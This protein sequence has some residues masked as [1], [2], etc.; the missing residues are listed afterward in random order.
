M[1]PRRIFTSLALGWLAYSQTAK[2]TFEVASVRPSA[3]FTRGVPE[4]EITDVTGDPE[5]ITYLR[6][7]MQELLLDAY[8]VGPD[9]I[10]GPDW[11][12]TSDVRA[13]ARFDISAKVPPGTTK[14]QAV[15]MLR[16]VLAERFRLALH[17]ETK[18]V[19]GFAL[20]LAK[21]GSK[22]K[23]SQGA[24]AA[25]ERVAAASGGGMQVISMELAK[26]GFP[27][28]RPVG[29]MGVYF[30]DGVVRDRFR[31]YPLSDWVQQLSQGLQAHVV[32]KTGLAG[33]YD[34]TL[35]L[36]TPPEEF[37]LGIAFALPLP[38]GRIATLRKDSRS[39]GQIDGVTILSAAMEK[40]L[41]LKLEAA[42]IPLDMLAIDHLE[43]NPSEN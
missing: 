16:N 24:P 43:R 23:A 40:Q 22:L 30:K 1:N 12:T 17:H 41:G 38:P 36:E 14:E 3:P 21:S 10:T 18:E 37:T 33:R 34:F 27:L 31:D 9:Q 20:V 42:K 28:L 4:N 2:L 19:S 5:R 13:A 26:D 35:E 25:S 32:D 39:D 11:A 8:G 6:V 29:N 15:E 7:P